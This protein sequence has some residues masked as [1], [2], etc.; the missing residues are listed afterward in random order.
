MFPPWC[1]QYPKLHCDSSFTAMGKCCGQ[2]KMYYPY[3][4]NQTIFKYE[5]IFVKKIQYPNVQPKTS[6]IALLI[7][8]K[9]EKT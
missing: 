5:C 9:S 1:Q 8:R 7:V 3:E 6:S 4:T 2:N